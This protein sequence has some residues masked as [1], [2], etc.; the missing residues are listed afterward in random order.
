MIIWNEQFKTGSETIDQQHQMLIQNINHL[1]CLLTETNPSRETCAF[2]VNLVEFLESYTRQHFRYE[3]GCME[4]HRC[5][6]HAANKQA[7]EEFLA[8]FKQFREDT[9]R[10]G[11]QPSAIRTLHQTISQWV[12]EHILRVDMQLKPCLNAGG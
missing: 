5:P 12:E 10:K 1:G 9:R 4:Q 2:L 11:I 6:A 7:H 8:F 3:E